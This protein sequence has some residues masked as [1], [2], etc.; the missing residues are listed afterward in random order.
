MQKFIC[1]TCN[2][3]T[4]YLVK[5]YTGNNIKIPG[6]WITIHVDK[7]Y[8]DRDNEFRKVVH[9]Q[10]EYHFCSKQCFIDYFF[11]KEIET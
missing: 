8:N 6:Q 11:Y 10:G 2:H 9:G 5:P 1:N 7:F 3:E 4:D